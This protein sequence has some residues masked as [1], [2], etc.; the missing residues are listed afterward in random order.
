MKRLFDA[1]NYPAWPTERMRLLDVS[2]IVVLVLATAVYV[3]PFIDVRWQIYEDAAMLFR[4]AQH[5]SAGHGIVWNIGDPPVDGATDLLFMWMIAGLNHLGVSI[6]TAARVIGTVAHLATIVL[7][8]VG[9]RTLGAAGRTAALLSATYVAIG[10]AKVYIAGGFGTTVFAACVALAWFT[11]L[12]LARNPGTR[13]AVACGC[14]FVLMGVARPEGALLA[15]YSVMALALFWSRDPGSRFLWPLVLTGAALGGAYWLWRW[16]YFGYPLPNPF[17]RKGNGHLYYGNLLI[18]GK[19]GALHLGVFLIPL[20]LGLADRRARR[21]ALLG[22]IP[23]LAFLASWI[24]L[25]NEMN[26]FRRFQYPVVPIAAMSWPLWIPARSARWRE[27]LLRGPAYR[28]VGVAAIAVAVI[29]SALVYQ[30]RHYAPPRWQDRLFEAGTDLQRYR[31]RG[32]TMAVSE[33]GL[34]PFYSQWR[35]IDAWGLNDQWI[36]HHGVV[37]AAYLDAQRPDLI[38]FRA[39]CRP[40]EPGNPDPWTA[41]VGVLTTYVRQHSYEPS[42]VMRLGD[43]SLTLF[44]VRRE[45]EDGRA[46]DAILRHRLQRDEDGVPRLP[47]CGAVGAS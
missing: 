30:H 13:R 12:R 14:A 37:S 41:M 23:I 5:V 46:I 16:S 26:F 25:S 21:M 24:L 35:T 27:A 6:E 15:I 31:D 3:A 43:G 44:F 11:V 20:A 34:L 36:A 47:D 22:G 40:T 7:I 4:Y 19:Y 1:G 17:Y 38:M 32:Y 28:R 29:V 33:A 9:A 18:T 42:A 8:F 2:V 45:L 10:P 39:E